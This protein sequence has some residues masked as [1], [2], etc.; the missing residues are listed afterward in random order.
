MP[1]SKIW[2]G[3]S[4][5]YETGEVPGDVRAE[6]KPKKSFKGKRVST[7]KKTKD[8]GDDSDLVV[9]SD[10]G[11]QILIGGNKEDDT[12]VAA[13]GHGRVLVGPLLAGSG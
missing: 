4:A 5:K 6:E 10:V 7:W 8:F 2:K 9:S 12:L 11:R 13:F 1:R 3:S